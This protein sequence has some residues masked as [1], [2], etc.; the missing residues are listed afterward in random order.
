MTSWIF[1]ELT[2]LLGEFLAV[3]SVACFVPRI[4]ALVFFDRGIPLWTVLARNSLVSAGR[5]VGFETFA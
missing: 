1:T 3:A 5:V 4:L 2:Q